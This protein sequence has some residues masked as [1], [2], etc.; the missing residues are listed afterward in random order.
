MNEDMDLT[1]GVI[2]KFQAELKKLASV[3]EKDRKAMVVV[4]TQNKKLQERLK[5]KDELIVGY[6]S[7]LREL[8]STKKCDVV[9]DEFQRKVNVACGLDGGEIR[10]KVD[11]ACGPNENIYNVV[12]IACGP[13]LSLIHI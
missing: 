10:K 6:R 9:D 7:V 1:T 8:A 5:K 12:E 2:A 3:I 4:Q 11:V 13:D